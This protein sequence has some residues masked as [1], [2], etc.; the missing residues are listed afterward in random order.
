MV[1]YKP[2]TMQHD[3]C[4]TT[5]LLAI[6]AKTA[7]AGHLDFLVPLNL[8]VPEVNVTLTFAAIASTSE[9][10]TYLNLITLTFVSFH[11]TELHVPD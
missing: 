5:A 10:F 8:S 2:D 6:I 3:C 1:R 9:L 4:T 11:F 7:K